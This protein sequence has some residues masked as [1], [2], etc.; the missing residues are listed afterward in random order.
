[1][2]ASLHFSSQFIVPFPAYTKYLGHEARL[3]SIE[4]DYK[5]VRGTY[6]SDV[7]KQCCIVQ[8]GSELGKTIGKIGD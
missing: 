5:L 6:C 7:V 4:S 1:M 2:L 3:I 8:T